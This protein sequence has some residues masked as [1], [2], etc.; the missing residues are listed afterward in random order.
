MYKS[1]VSDTTDWKYHA[2]QAVKFDGGIYQYSKINNISK[3]ALYRWI[4]ICANQDD[5][6]PSQKSK[7][8]NL[9]KSSKKVSPFLPV[10]ITP[11]KNSQSETHELKLNTKLPDSRWVAEIITNVIRGLL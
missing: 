2:E 1:R 4:K 3:S 9:N 11:S 6:K 7:K 5:S 8:V 10:V